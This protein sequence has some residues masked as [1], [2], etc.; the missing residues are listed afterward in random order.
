MQ[1]FQTLP[2]CPFPVARPR[3]ENYEKNL[4]YRT[5]KEF[6]GEKEVKGKTAPTDSN[7]PP[8]EETDP[9]FM[10]VSTFRKSRFYGPTR[11]TV[12]QAISLNNRMYEIL[13][14]Q[15]DAK[16]PIYVD[17]QYVLLS[18]GVR[19]RPV[20]RPDPFDLRDIGYSSS[21]IGSIHQILADDVSMYC[22]L[23]EDPGF[24]IAM[25]EK[26]KSPSPEDKIKMD[27]LGH[28]LLIMGDK[29]LPTWRERERLG[30]VLE[31]AT[32]DT[33]AIDTVA[34]QRTFNRRNELIDI[35]YLDPATIFR[36]DPKKGY[37][38]DKSITHV[39]M[40]R[41]QVTEVYEAGR[42]VLRHKN[43]SSDVRFRGF[44]IS[45]IESC[46][47]EIMSLIFVIKHNADRF[48]SRNPPRALI[49]S[50]GNISKADQEK[51]ELEW[52]NAYFGARSGFRLPML[53][54]AGKI[55]VHNLEVNDDFEFDKLLQMTASLICARYGIDPA[56]LG[57]K[58]NQSATLSEPSVDGRQ[59][60]ARDRS[61]G[62]LMAFHRDCLNEVH[63]PQDDSP[64]KLIF[65]G[66]KVDESSK[67]ADLYDKQFK[68]FRTLD[69]IL[70]AEDRP[71][72]KELADSYKTTGVISDEQAKKFAQMGMLIGNPYFAAEFSKILGNGSQPAQTPFPGNS[73][74]GNPN[75]SSEGAPSQNQ[76]SGPDQEDELP[77]SDEDF[78]TPD[79]EPVT[80]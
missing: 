1:C 28:L 79:S 59:H 58:L 39:Q 52:E 17:D 24:S 71:T 74:D 64:Y 45:P 29:S 54:G 80:Q 56:Q 51:L 75:S 55:Q 37:K 5:P 36:V 34:Y 49:T 22:D 11:A 16:D 14:T 31:M 20:F 10:D 77:W 72:M 27:N 4:H 48:N 65:N 67:K 40:I 46:I 8:K 53:F 3:G 70:K 63:D 47:L 43:N 7:S 2:N 61:H 78:I 42:I 25:K 33:L 9:R 13:R 38:G 62:S 15:K 44:G 19:C 68:T 57:L 35:T 6:R 41:N 23:D 18:Q 76:G 50:E 12:D 26:R 73:P 60:F 30:E 69:D 66:V 21:L 32:R